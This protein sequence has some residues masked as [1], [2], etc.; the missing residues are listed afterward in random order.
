MFCS[1]PAFS[2][3]HHYPQSNRA[4]LVLIPRWVVCVRSRNLWISLTSSPVRLGVSST[5]TSTPTGVFNLWFEALFPQAGAL[6]CMLCCWVCQLVSCWPAAVLPTPVLQPPPCCDSSLPGCPSP[7]FLLV[8][9]S[10]S[11]LS[12]WLL[13]F[14]TVRFFCH[15]WLLFVFKLLLS[16]FW[17]FEEARCVCLCLYLGQKSLSCIFVCLCA[18]IQEMD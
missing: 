16:S 12:P 3:F 2:H 10:V 14:H 11:S 15:F 13:D 9:V 1:L 6:G 17:L 7:P 5:A 4:L 8:W 18:D